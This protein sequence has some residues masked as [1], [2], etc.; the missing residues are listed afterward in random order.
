MAIKLINREYFPYAGGVKCDYLCDKDTDFASLPK[1]VTG[2]TAVSIESGTVK[3]V[4]T[5]G[6]WVTFGG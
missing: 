4:N 2:S 3:I 5:E 1:A 6:Q